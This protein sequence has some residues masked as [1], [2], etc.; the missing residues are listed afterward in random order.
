MENKEYILLRLFFHVMYQGIAV[1]F[2]H[3]LAFVSPFCHV[4][5]LHVVNEDDFYVRIARTQDNNSIL[6]CLRHIGLAIGVG[7][8]W[9]DISVNRRRWRGVWLWQFDLNGVWHEQAAL[10]CSGGQQEECQKVL[11]LS[12]CLAV[13]SGCSCFLAFAMIHFWQFL[14]IDF[15]SSLKNIKHL[16]SVCL[17]YAG[18]S[19]HSFSS[20]CC[21]I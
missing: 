11:E 20:Y 8:E 7:H 1:R 6:A 18:I 9:H 17:S 10:G 15:L 16:S 3:I 14:G 12:R 19:S 21:A 4:H 5:H 13:L 2:D